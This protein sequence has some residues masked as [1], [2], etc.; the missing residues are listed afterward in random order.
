[1][2]EKRIEIERQTDRQTDRRR[3]RETE[4]SSNRKKKEN[5]RATLAM[6]IKPIKIVIMRQKTVS[7][8]QHGDKTFPRT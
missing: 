3:A 6:Y 8:Y 2:R 1:M 4:R 7:K 5:D